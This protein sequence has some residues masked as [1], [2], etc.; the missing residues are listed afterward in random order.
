MFEGVV[1]KGQAV[2]DGLLKALF[3]WFSNVG[4]FI[5]FPFLTS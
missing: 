3:L 1:W 2:K 4:G 5:I